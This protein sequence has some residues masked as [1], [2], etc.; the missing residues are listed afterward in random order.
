MDPTNTISPTL[1]IQPLPAF[2]SGS[3]QQRPPFSFT[4][5]QLLQGI[6]SAKSGANQFTIDIGGRQVLAES[7]AQLQVG[8]KLNLQVATLTPQVELQIVSSSTSINRMIGNAI[9]L[10]GP[11]T[12]LSS[13][14]TELA[15]KSGLPPQLSTT[16][17]ET[18]QVYT[19]TIAKLPQGTTESLSPARLNVQLL[20]RALAAFTAP[21][22]PDLEAIY[23]EIGTLLQQ[24]SQASF[25]PPKMAEFATSLAA[26]FTRLSAQQLSTGSPLQAE[27]AP[28]A[29]MATE[30]TVYLLNQ[31]AKLYP[32]NPQIQNLISRLI[33]FLQENPTLPATTDPLQQLITLLSSLKSEQ[34]QSQPLQLDG[35]QLQQF[36]DRLGINMERLLADGNLE[37]A[38]QTLKFALLE[39][40]QQFPAGDKNSVQADQIIK[41]IELYQT[42]QIR[43]ASESLS[44]VPL[45]FSF[46]NQGYLL[47]DSDRSK[48]ESEEQAGLS[49][50]TAQRF[51]LHLQLEGLGNLQIDIRQKDGRVA[52]KFL[53]EDTERAKFIAGFRNE[54][55][56][57]L[58]TANLESAQFLVGAKEPVKSLLEKIISGA[59]GMVDTKA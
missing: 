41:T 34:T 15:G 49:E 16:S 58:T 45:P 6:V 36:V 25:F 44:F 46:L 11:Q 27:T 22:A 57:W 53:T 54:L 40:S 37:K 20:S 51:E 1:R 30:D 50:K 31:T 32:D 13:G 3:Q 19:D 4:Q 5:G 56:Q 33:L 52:M 39:F 28:T 55:E 43:L 9:H 17:K 47:I 29:L 8:Q 26:V 59:T 23:K 10:I 24:L 35:K 2:Q 21:H 48:R 38:T 12:A 14:L 18:L 7:A 42:L